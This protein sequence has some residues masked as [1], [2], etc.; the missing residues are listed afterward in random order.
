[1]SDYTDVDI[2]NIS[3]TLLGVPPIAGMD[4]QSDVAA[5]LSRLYPVK[6]D[7]ILA[8]FNWRIAVKKRQLNKLADQTPINEWSYAYA[9]PADMIEGPHAVFGDGS[10][11]PTSDWE[12]YDG[13]LYCDYDTVII[14]YTA[15][16][17]ESKFPPL[18]GE[19]IAT[20]VA[21]SAAI[22]L[23]ESADRANELRIQAYGPAQLDGN[24]GLYAQ[25]KRAVSQTQGT[26]SLFKNGD[27]LT[28][29]RY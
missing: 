13:L 4:E 1:M 20:V 25:A 12:V 14:D 17:S 10:D 2:C 23:T 24:G 6:R 22:P 27:P 11:T 8:A 26:K 7:S 16:P 19:F 15:R 29:S 3:A 21:M 18:L 28:G 5:C 9:M